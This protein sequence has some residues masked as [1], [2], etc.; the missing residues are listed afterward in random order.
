[1]RPHHRLAVTLTVVLLATS[2]CSSSGDDPTPSTTTGNATA[3]GTASSSA[4]STASA[5]PSDVGTAAPDELRTRPAVAAAIA[6]AA[7][8]EKLRPDEVVIAAW[9]PVTWN[10]GSLGCPTKGK[11]YTQALVDGELLLLQTETGL[12]QYNAKAGGRFAYCASPSSNYS[13]GG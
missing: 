5:T 3:T 4:S 6:D 9:S 8:R 10:D 11:S 2:A 1:M 13:V 7:K 12:F